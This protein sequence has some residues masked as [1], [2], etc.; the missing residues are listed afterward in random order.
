MILICERKME[1]SLK[2][3]RELSWQGFADLTE[4]SRKQ[5]MKAISAGQ[6]WLMVLAKARACIKE[7]ALHTMNCC[8][9]E[10]LEHKAEGIF[11]DIIYEDAMWCGQ[12]TRGMVVHPQLVVTSP[13]TWSMP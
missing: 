13:G 4:L 1:V 5:P 10:A 11:S 9:S 2:K 3:G 8:I 6:S 7:V 12:Q